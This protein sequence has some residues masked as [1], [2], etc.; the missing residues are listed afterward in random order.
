M[1]FVHESNLGAVFNSLM[2]E[3]QNDG[4]DTDKADKQGK[5]WEKSELSEWIHEVDSK[6]AGSKGD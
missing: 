2:I 1:V 6:E 5:D 3:A 4:I